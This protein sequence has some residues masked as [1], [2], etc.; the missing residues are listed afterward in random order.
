MPGQEHDRDLVDHLGF[1]KR[2]AG[3]GVWGCHDPRG[4]IVGR[5][6]R[7]DGPTTRAHQIADQPANARGGGA[8]AARM[9]P[10]HPGGQGQQGRQ[11]H[12]GLSG[13]MVAERL[14]HVGRNAVF[15]RHRKQRA[16]DHVGGGM[17][18]LRL[19]VLH[20]RR[21]PL[22]GRARGGQNGGKAVAQA[23]AVK[24]RVDD[25]PLACPIR[26]V[27]DEDA[28][29][30]QRRQTLAH[31]VRFREIARPILQDQPD[32]RR[33]V[34]EE[35]V[36]HRTA[37]FRHPRAVQAFRQRAQQVAPE[38]ADQP[39]QRPAP[40]CALGAGR[41]R[42][43]TGRVIRPGDGLRPA[44]RCASVRGPAVIAK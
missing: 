12:Q 22:A 25:A 24:G 33:V 4:Q 21:Q 43:P 19:D 36:D 15:D 20:P 34:A 37:E 1:G 7:R 26:A 23:A 31:A 27:R 38:P 6:A 9:G 40:L 5:R 42:A 30:Q 44:N 8:G 10:R 11:V 16:K 29:A 13:L 39:A 17:G 3:V 32:Q 41:H 28:V 2:R 35:A 18:G 14:E